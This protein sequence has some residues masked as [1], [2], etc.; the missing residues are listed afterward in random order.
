M[1]KLYLIVIMVMMMTILTSTTAFAGS[2]TPKF[3]VTVNNKTVK[4]D[5]KPYM[6][7]QELMI[8]VKQ[9]AEALGAKV[10]SDDK[11]K[12]I[13]VNLGMMHVE[14]PIGKSEFY[15]HRDADFSGI[16]QTI[17]LKTA[18]KK[19]KGT[20]FVPGQKFIES[21]GMTVSWS[22]KK[23]VLS[24]KYNSADSDTS[25]AIPYTEITKD[26]ISGLK[27]V[28]KWYNVNYKKSGIHYTKHDGVMYVLVGAGSKPT[29]GYEIGI[30]RVSYDTK[31]KA[32]V[33][34]Y[35]KRPTPDMMVTQVET[36]PH[37]LIMMK[38]CK[39]LKTIN[40]DV[41]E[42]IIDTIPT[43]VP[44][45]EIIVDDIKD[46]KILNNWYNENNQKKGISY[47]RDGKYIY[48]LIGAGEKPTGGYTLNIDNVFYST[49]DTVTINARVT[50]PGDNVRVMMVITY[51]STLIRIESESIKTIIGEIV[52]A[53]TPNKEKWITMDSSTVT[54]MEL[55]TIDQVK[56]RDITGAEKDDIMKS[57]NEAT[58]DPNGYV[59]MIAGS[60]LKVT[61]NDG[62][63]VTFTSYGSET[64]VI[65]N[66]EKDGESRTFHLVAPVIA[67]ILLK[68]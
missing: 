19:V 26:D 35:V 67:K 36:F 38:G 13:W 11:N 44:Y 45:E 61:T 12:A 21:L 52:D 17:T 29:G 8:P 43:K 32:F 42:I 49:Y 41:Q 3:K 54:K 9:T 62:Y 18:I 22:S 50:P 58:L 5:V 4:Y 68:A 6:K 53:T 10:E 16:P 24:I 63:V 34:A 7:G 57:F 2:S 46:N 33:S 59:K 66:F 14:L 28:Y 60:V 20:V 1:K 30:N 64:N 15:I 51:P 39:N 23:G 27:D 48:A 40:G 37:M 31:T 56:L 65:I 25:E 47:I 55:F